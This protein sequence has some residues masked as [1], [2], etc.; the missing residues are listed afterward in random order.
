MSK[1][2]KV[3][4]RKDLD[5]ILDNAWLNLS[6]DEL[7][8]LG[9][10]PLANGLFDDGINIPAN[11]IRAMKDPDNF[12]FV[13]KH[14]LNITI[15][16]IQHLILKELWTKPFPMFI[17]LRGFGKCVT[18]NTFI[19]TENKVD[20]I[21]NLL[22]QSK[23]LEDIKQT[24]LSFSKVFGENG[25]NSVEYGWK[26]S[27]RKIVNIETSQGFQIGCTLDN[28]LR[29]VRDGEIQW[30]EVKDIRL[31]DYL[32]IDRTSSWIEKDN[33]LDKDI[34]YILGLLIGDGGYTVRGRIS[35][36]TKDKHLLDKLNV[37]ALRLWN[38]EF[39]QA[40]KSSLIDFNLYGV[41]IW[42]EL[43]SKYG[44]NSSVCGEKDV[45]S[46][47]LSAPKSTVAAFIS[48]L[49]DTDGWVCKNAKKMEY[50]SKSENLV[51]SLQFLLTR[52]G[53]IGRVRKRLNKKYDRNYWYL[54]LFGDN[55]NL[56]R[57]SIGFGLD[58]KQ[59]R[60]DTICN[61]KT[62]TNIDIV[63]TELIAKELRDYP[64][65]FNF[66]YSP[67]Y[68]KLDGF[69]NDAKIKELYDKHYFYDKVVSLELSEDYTYDVHIPND[70]SFIANGFISHN[71]FLLGLYSILR[72][73]LDQGSKVVIAGAA[74]R[75]AR[76]VFEYMEQI[77]NN[78]PILKDICGFVNAKSGD[79]IGPRHETDRY[80]FLIGKSTTVAIP[81][82]SGEKIRGL[83]A[84]HLIV[85]EFNSVPEDIY[86]IV[87]Q[88]FTSVTKNPIENIKMKAKERKMK[89][90][91]MLPET[92]T[93]MKLQSNQSILVGTAG[94]T[95]QHFYKYWKRYHAIISSKG[96]RDKLREVY[97]DEIPEDFDHRDYS[98]IR[99][100]Y[101]LMPKGM[102]DDKVVAR[103]KA[104]LGKSEYSNE[105]GAAFSDDSGGFFKRS[106]IDSCVTGENSIV[107]SDRAKQWLIDNR[108][109]AAL[110]GHR[111]YKY[112]FGV[113]PASEVDNFSIVILELHN[114]HRRI[115][116]T[117]TTNRKQFKEKLNKNQIKESDFYVYCTKKI[118]TLMRLFP[119]SLIA[120]DSQGGGYTIS[121]CL[122]N[123][124]YV[125]KATFEKPIW[126]VID[127]EKEADTDHYHG[128]H[129]L[130]LVN[131]AKAEWTSEANHGLRRDLENKLLL[132]PEFDPILLALSAEDDLEKNRLFDTLEDCVMEIEELKNE[133]VSIVHTQTPNSGRDKWDTPEIKL[134]NNKK[135]RQRKDRYSALLMANAEAHKI[136]T[137]LPEIVLQS[138]GGG[139]VNQ[140]DVRSGND[141]RLYN[142]PD[143]FI[144]E[145]MAKNPY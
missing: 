112:V 98:I 46:C 87:L 123:E 21:S 84:T 34:G 60:L 41:E 119:C 142:G 28:K 96:N 111:D 66:D 103:A 63:P 121:E 50:C 114:D 42:D 85:E 95:F 125:D 113:D 64:K 71:T 134:P 75:Q 140:I 54:S 49:F 118:R 2:T 20:R 30:I 4:T 94:Y 13:C 10:G 137:I 76:F 56:F 38:K 5:L 29:T 15:P 22:N 117:W 16:P 27:L 107:P 55:I 24:D 33:G 91:G 81:L 110:M 58:R 14:I 52:F 62:N 92:E 138:A 109:D 23:I 65:F 19:I 32:P 88:G 135:G 83:R 73:M 86:E 127:P 104:T 122:H 37:V 129:I 139:F 12:P 26:N 48:G 44:F 57:D 61:I 131:F 145:M 82:G 136:Q 18:G 128:L 97:Q 77:W 59:E 25:F 120:M 124:E 100:P 47:I 40:R 93:L 90:M 89:D 80:T 8:D 67:T 43:F 132:F 143:W 36:T 31:G 39:K 101:E 115:V 68:Y 72:N 79:R 7:E 35:F 74:F 9:P 133:L 11:L 45:P 51:R 78:A 3:L 17:A 144:K 108:F 69:L 1:K 126:P 70:H 105:Y 130:Q 106:V 6:Q 102:M 53:I 141:G 99:I 116:Y